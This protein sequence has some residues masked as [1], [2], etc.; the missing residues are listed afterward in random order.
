M[1][2][3]ISLTSHKFDSSIRQERFDQIQEASKL[4]KDDRFLL[5]LAVAVDVLEDSDEHPN[6]G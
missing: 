6:F 3:H 4:G 1:Q 2:L 5:A